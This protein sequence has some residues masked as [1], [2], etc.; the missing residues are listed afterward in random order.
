MLQFQRCMEGE[1]RTSKAVYSLLPDVVTPPGS[2]TARLG[3][4]WQAY[5]YNTTAFAMADELNENTS[6]VEARVAELFDSLGLTLERAFDIS[7]ADIKHVNTVA[8]GQKAVNYGEVLL[9]SWA[10]VLHAVITLAGATP[11]SP[12]W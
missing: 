7:S 2:H 8:G 1:T 12:P 6:A 9:S 5:R 3:A 4:E 11:S 10:A